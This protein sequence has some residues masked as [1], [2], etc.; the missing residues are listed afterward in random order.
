MKP[1]SRRLVL[2]FLLSL[3][4]VAACSTG[5]STHHH[6]G[7]AALTLRV[8]QLRSN[9]EPLLAAAGQLKSLPYKIR[10]SAF[11][12]GPDAIAAE[13]AGAVD[14][15]YMA[16]TPPIFAQAAH[17]DVKIVGLTR[18][19]GGA[20]NVGLIVR[21][22]TGAESVA[23]LAGKKV[24]VVPGTV[25]Q[26][27]LIR[28]LA[29]SG[30]ALKDVQQVNL[31]GPEAIAALEAGDV[32]AIVLVDPLLATALTGGDTRVVVN[33]SA[34]LSGSTVLVATQQ[35]LVDA[36]RAR[37][38][39]DLLARVKLALVW[40]REHAQAWAAVYASTYHLPMAAALQAVQRSAT[41]LVPIDRAAIAAQQLQADTFASIGLL[42]RHLDVA[43]EFDDR[44]NQDL[45]KAQPDGSPASSTTS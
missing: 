3:T 24:A 10:W 44:Y 18:A 12:V 7:A 33:G 4:L 9:L 30:L 22:G 1:L 35:A 6:R 37:A 29:Q 16:D 11:D 19:P 38:I 2:A 28:A 15:A 36:S 45:F 32:N 5:A 26:Y 27:L 20:A 14:L 23:D 39:A 13:T 8:A 41:A 42:K 40:A 31:P 17:V 25:T 43:Q 34:L 21:T